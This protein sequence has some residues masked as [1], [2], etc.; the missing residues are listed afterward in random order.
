VRRRSLTK[1]LT[2]R[3]STTLRDQISNTL[4]STSQE[5]AHGTVAV[6]C[7]YIIFYRFGI[8]E[9]IAEL[10]FFKDDSF[11][12]RCVQKDV[13]VVNYDAS[14]GKTLRFSLNSHSQLHAFC[15]LR[16][17]RKMRESGKS[18]RRWVNELNNS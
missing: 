15:L 10:R 7:E 9:L 18:R 12:L 5:S 2:L 13:E 8:G 16:A 17:A 14:R 11:S 1:F 3:S 6:Q 4:I